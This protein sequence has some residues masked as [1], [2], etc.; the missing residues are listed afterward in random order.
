MA[1]TDVLNEAADGRGGCADYGEVIRA[2][3]RQRDNGLTILRSQRRRRG[4]IRDCATSSSTRFDRVGSIHGMI[5]Q[6]TGVISCEMYRRGAVGLAS[7]L[8]F[9]TNRGKGGRS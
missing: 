4:E 9:M 5:A 8:V 2:V 7:Q 1:A 3:I 6:T